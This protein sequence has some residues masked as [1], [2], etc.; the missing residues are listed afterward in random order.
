MDYGLNNSKGNRYSLLQK[1]RRKLYFTDR[2]L[3]NSGQRQS[4]TNNQLAVK[5][6]QHNRIYRVMG[7]AEQ[8]G[9]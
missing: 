8:S 2:H 5:N 4:F 7:N 1:V 9:F 3:K 6:L